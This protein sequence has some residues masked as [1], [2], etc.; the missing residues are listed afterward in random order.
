MTPTRQ[1][2]MERLLL[3]REET[4]RVLSIA[5]ESV[6]YLHRVKSLPAVRVGRQLRWKPETVREYVKS[7]E[8]AR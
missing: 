1:E 8:S 6:T 7:L 5:P 3:T 4:A 2:L